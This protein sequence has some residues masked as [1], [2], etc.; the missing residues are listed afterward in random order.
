LLRFDM[1]TLAAQAGVGIGLIELRQGS[2]ESAAKRFFDCFSVFHSAGYLREEAQTLSNLGVIY[3]YKQ[4]YR[5]AMAFFAQSMSLQEKLDDRDDLRNVYNNAADCCLHLGD[6][7]TAALYY[8]KLLAMAEDDGDARGASTAFAGLAEVH[9][10][11]GKQEE[12]EAY[13][14]RS[15]DRAES[16]GQGI[17]QGVAYRVLADVA[18]VAE[19]IREALQLYQRSISILERSHEI[20][21][22]GKARRGCDFV[23]QL[24]PEADTA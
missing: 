9:L 16:A 13:A 24:L 1:L 19:K 12:A 18:L 6:F 20:D 17:E 4:N 23:C 3:F 7:R 15:L 11:M 8:N 2:L 10:V 21:E 14:R 22:L 5:E